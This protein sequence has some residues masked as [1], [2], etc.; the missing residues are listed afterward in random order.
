M[1]DDLKHHNLTFTEIAKLVGENWQ[2]LPPAEKE[3]YEGQANAAKEKYHRDLSEYKKTPQYRKY[4]Q[5]LQEFKERQ[6]KQNS[7][8]LQMRCSNIRL[9]NTDWF[10]DSKRTKL[11]PARLRH[12]SSSSSATPAS[13]SGSGSMRGSRSSSERMQG[14]EPPPARQE[15]VNSIESTAES[16]QSLPGLGFHQHRI[17]LDEPNF[18]P[19]T[20]HF[21]MKNGR[22]APPMQQQS[23]PSLSDVLDDGRIGCLPIAPQPEG[24]P[25]LAHSPHH[26]RRPLVD[27]QPAILPARVPVLRHEGSSSGSSGSGSSA[28]SLGRPLGDGPL[29]I[30]ALLSNRPP[31]PYE[32]SPSP[33]FSNGPNGSSHGP[34]GY[35]KR[36]HIL[37]RSS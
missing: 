4:A 14:S 13:G 8:L 26:H 25:Y 11:E 6:A 30:H 27:A 29:P 9:T 28:S 34:R 2:S 22:D 3:A 7:G 12:G 31:A 33:T 10:I 36:S 17:S 19:R 5:Y 35:G 20:E 32:Q 16:H 1:R 18:S 23:L 21:E 24:S 37:F 15:R